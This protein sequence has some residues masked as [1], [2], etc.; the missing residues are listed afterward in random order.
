[1]NLP[2]SGATIYVQLWTEL[3]RRTILS[4][5]N[6]YTEYAISQAPSPAP[7]PGSTLTGGL[8]DFHMER[9]P[10]GVTAYYLHIGT[11]RRLR[12]GEHRPSRYRHQ[13]T[14]NLPTNGATIYV[15]L[16]TQFSG[17]SSSPTTTLTPRPMSTQPPSPVRRRAAR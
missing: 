3:Q 1:M 7:S 10:G 16:W 8:N 6:T 14:V 15:Q 4:N 11:S 5:S 17:G 12:S 9:R 2:T 13:R